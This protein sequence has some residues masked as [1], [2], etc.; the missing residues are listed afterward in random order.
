MKSML[1]MKKLQQFVAKLPLGYN[2]LKVYKKE[3]EGKI[4]GK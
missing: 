1:L 4:D 2:I 3:E